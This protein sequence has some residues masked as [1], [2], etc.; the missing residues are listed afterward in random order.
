LGEFADF[1]NS[2]T[3]RELPF[4][5]GTPVVGARFPALLPLYQWLVDFFAQWISSRADG[6]GLLTC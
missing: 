1:S 6:G 2:A 4:A 3:K 5:G